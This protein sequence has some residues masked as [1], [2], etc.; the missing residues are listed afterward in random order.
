[1]CSCPCG[2]FNSYHVRCFDF[3]LV[4]AVL[5]RGLD[6]VPACQTKTGCYAHDLQR[7]FSALCLSHAHVL[8]TAYVRTQ[9]VHNGDENVGLL[10]NWS[11]GGWSR[12]FWS[13]GGENI[14]S[15]SG[16]AV[17]LVSLVECLLGGEDC[18]KDGEE[19]DHKG[20]CRTR[21]AEH[22][23]RRLGLWRDGRVWLGR[24][25]GIWLGRGR[26][27]SVA[28]SVVSVIRHG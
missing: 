14:R 22:R 9:I 18:Q 11:R 7:Y 19:S 27:W 10:L 15:R 28:T 25:W 5:V 24:G 12:G 20:H 17:V 6:V 13:R 2:W 21:P 26:L 16:A 1:M 23:G 4:S 3:S 8:H